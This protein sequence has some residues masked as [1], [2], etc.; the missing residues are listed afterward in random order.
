MNAAGASFRVAKNRLA[1]RALKGTAIEG[2]SPLFKGP[3]G[4]AYS[5][6][7]VAASKVAA[8]YAKD[9]DKLVILGGSVGATTLDAAASKPSRPCRRS[10][11][12]EARSWVCSL[13]PP[14]R[15]PGSCG[16]RRPVGPRHR[17]VFQEGS[18][19]SGTYHQPFKLEKPK[20]TEKCRKSKRSLKT[21]RR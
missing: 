9:N 5:D 18:G 12:P 14:R 13:H 2:I 15:L 17:C 10:T 16:S 8:A 11:K 19:I 3:T 20:E 4:I 21:C 7:P 1:V 6:D